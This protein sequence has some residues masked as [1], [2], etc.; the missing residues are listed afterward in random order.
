MKWSDVFLLSVISLRRGKFH[1]ALA[2]IGVS[3]GAALLA[4]MFSLGIGFNHTYR[5]PTKESFALTLIT[6]SVNSEK[7]KNPLSPASLDADVID[8]FSQMDHVTSASLVYRFPAITYH[9]NYEGTLQIT[10]VS[11]H[12]MYALNLPLLI[13]DLPANGDPFKLVAGKN[14]GYSL[15][16]GKKKNEMQIDSVSPGV[17]MY[18]TN[19]FMIF[20]VEGYDNYLG[21]ITDTVPQKYV[22]E[23]TAIIGDADDKSL[24]FE[25]DSTTFADIDAVIPVISKLHIKDIWANPSIGSNS[26]RANA[27][28]FTEAY[29]VV[30]SA[31]NVEHVQNLIIE[32][33][34][35]AHSQID[36]IKLAKEQ[37]TSTQFI[38]GGMGC[39]ALVVAAMGIMNA[40][41]M[42]IMEQSDEIGLYK[43]LG[44]SAKTI[45]NIYLF[46]ALLIGF[47]GGVIGILLISLPASAIINSNTDLI[48]IITIPVILFGFCLSVLTGIASGVAPAIKAMRINPIKV[49]KQL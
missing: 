7:N 1:C 10:A 2:M 6:V 24:P 8:A 3:A 48:S 38:L 26:H 16:D 22:I 33:G 32:N 11:L 44:C 37:L 20:D 9:G 4:V 42:N 5:N 43:V 45:R 28:E 29:V 49:I 15:E 25:F 30:D 27:I 31:D 19:L 13:G 14:A 39:I 34:Y 12:M 18:H 46:K 40:L 35:M 17:D 36:G 23:T 41:T 21:G 47:G